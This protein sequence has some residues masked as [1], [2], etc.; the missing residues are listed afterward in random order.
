MSSDTVNPMP[1]TVA[2]PTSGGH[3][4]VRGNP[5]NRGR[6]TSQVMPTMPSGLP[7][8]SPT[9]MPREI[10]SVRTFRTTSASR[11]TPALARAKSGTIT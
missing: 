6:D 2:A 7:T 9:T 10:G 4:T 8:T 3:G 1:A 5:P 11:V